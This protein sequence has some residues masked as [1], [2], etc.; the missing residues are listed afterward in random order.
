MKKK[1]N[2]QNL[3]HRGMPKFLLRMKL[4]T[5]FI[6]VSIASVAANSY[7]QQTKFNMS[8]KN[9]TVRHVFQ[10]IE[11]NSEFIILY[12]EKSVNIERKIRVDVSNQSVNHILD[13]IFKETKN[14]YEIHDRQI[15]VMEKGT[16]ELPVITQKNQL[17]EQ[18]AK[19]ISGKVTD[20]LGGPLP[21]VS[22]IIKGTTQGTITDAN[23]NYSLENVLSDGTLV[24]S[25]VGMKTQEI[26]IAG[27][28][29][30]D[31][32]MEEETIGLEE[33]V[34]VGYGTQKKSDITGTVAS[35]PK[36]RLENTPNINIA[37]AIQG[38]IPGVMIQ[39][40][41]AGADPNQVIMIRGRNSILADN[42]PLIVVDGIPYNGSI[43]DL[44]PNDIQSIEV[45]KDASSAAIYGSRGSNGVILISTKEG[46][47]GKVKITYDGFYSL[48]R[49][50]FLPDYMDGAEFYDFKMKRFSGAMTQ[51]EKDIYESGN[52]TNWIE[53]GLRNG[54]TQQHT[55][56][57]SGGSNKTKFF[58]SGSYLD[59]R[60]LAVNDDFQRLTSRINIDTKIV[61]WLT[62]GSRTQ[63]SFD[64][65]SG[66]GPD[67]SDLFQ[68]N[69]LTKA[70]EEDGSLAIYIWDDDH[71]FGNPLQM[72]LYD[73]IDK[74]YQVLSNNYLIVD[75]PFISGLSYRLNTGFSVRFFDEATYMGRDTKIGLEAKGVAETSR[76]LSNN[77]VIENIFTY[78]KEFGKN[79]L[80]GTAVLSYEN[81]SSSTNEMTANGFPHDFLK[82]YS[83]AQAVQ[84]VPDFSYNKTILMSQ[85][86]R[87]NYVYDTKYL[88]TFTGRRDGYSGFGFN[89]KWG[90]FPSAALGWNMH[91]EE[92]FP[93]KEIFNE[94]K[95]RASYGLNGNQ[96][97]GAYQSISRL[98]EY[99]MVANK[100][101]IAGYI[102]SRLGQENLGWESSRTFNLGLDFGIYRSRIIGNINW[103]KTNTTDLLLNRSISAVHGITSI[104]QNIGETANRGI[105]LFIQSRNIVNSDFTWT[106]SGNIAYNANKI[107]SLYG[108]IDESGKEIDDVSNA[109]FIGKPI[110]VNYDF[111]WEGTW[112]QNEVDEAAAWGTKPG[113]V[114]LKDFQNNGE[115][116]ADDKRIQGQSD[117]KF[118]WGLSNNFGYKGFNLNIF[119]HGVHGVTKENTL[120]TDETWADVRRNTINKNWWTPENATN[121]WVVNELNAERMSGI[122]GVTYENASFIRV[123]DI[124]LS[125]T[126]PKSVLNRSLVNNMRFF[127]TGRNLATF[128]KWRGLDPEL[129]S[130]RQIPLQREFVIGLNF[131][132]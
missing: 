33:V 40:S 129:D 110:R 107:I 23:G 96:A 78:N 32:V 84:V 48:Q 27:K 87:L 60:G 3:N 112:Q 119:I 28:T 88:A 128:T 113:F 18:Q 116:G 66:L 72:T 54:E 53:T 34:A 132:F 125:Y 43:S 90:L 4:L 64:D 63:I 105:E 17:E 24:F 37:Q 130:Q 8:F 1:R 5:F 94:L 75:F 22:V 85:M 6:F 58:I 115:L 106:T 126:L 19:S 93:W 16:K 38:S 108:E 73:N 80:F 47:E 7:S 61:D 12:S 45:L 131:D 76:S 15:V 77:T 11:N 109:W 25:F 50:A 13:Q 65:K 91:N 86:L 114:K 20:A 68:T 26:P 29:T 41:S 83:S 71:Y 127:I 42:S 97:V 9:V 122:L 99:N 56:S 98:S 62:I 55:L 104:T 36:E 52:W 79:N 49:F 120:M 81:N 14:Y 103:F 31:V 67:I 74:S 51:S 70:Y 95:L 123:K 21:G 117:P 124:S 35:I 111:V 46:V 100:Q 118:I 82:W 30:F 121:D 10:E 2:R 57:V 59:V 102:P 92:F 44:N 69:P 89:S 101:T 39:T